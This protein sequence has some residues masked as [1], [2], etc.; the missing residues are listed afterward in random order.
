MTR[1]LIFSLDASLSF[2]EGLKNNDDMDE[3][4]NLFFFFF[5]GALHPSW[6]FLS[7][8]FQPEYHKVTV[9]G[10]GGN[11]ETFSCGSKSKIVPKQRPARR[12]WY[13]P[14]LLRF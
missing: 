1:S 10:S 11:L 6:A 5:L 14:P 3:A 4:K 12:A 2:V 8:H 13:I 7:L 9:S